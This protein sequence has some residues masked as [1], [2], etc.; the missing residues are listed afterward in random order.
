M[1]SDNAATAADLQRV[2]NTYLTL[3]NRTFVYFE[4]TALTVQAG[5]TGG[6][7]QTSESF[8]AGPPV[9]PAE[10]AKYLPPIQSPG[11]SQSQTLPEEFRLANGVRVLLLQDLSSPTVTLSGNLLAGAEFASS[12]KAGLATLTAVNLMNGTKTRDALSLGKALGENG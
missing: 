2:A 5:A 4:P 7:A 12:A 9:D 1:A 3:A 6:E 10:V 11:S 8:N